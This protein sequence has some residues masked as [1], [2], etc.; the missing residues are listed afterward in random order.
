MLGGGGVV[1][2]APARLPAATHQKGSKVS[3]IIMKREVWRV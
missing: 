2:A 3:Q 1:Q